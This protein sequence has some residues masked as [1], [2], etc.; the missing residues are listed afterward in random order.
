MAGR[1]APAVMRHFGV[2]F[3]LARD[4]LILLMGL[5]MLLCIPVIRAIARISRLP[6][7][8]HSQAREIEDLDTIAPTLDR[9][10]LRKGIQILMGDPKLK[11]MA[12]LIVTTG[13]AESLILYLFYWLVSDQVPITAGRTLFFSDFYIWVNAWTLV[14]LVFGSNRLINRFGLFLALAALPFA[15]F[16]G[17]AYLLYHTAVAAMYVVRIVYSS[18]EQSLYGQGLDRMMLDIEPNQAPIAR[19]LLHGLAVRVGRGM[20][21]VLVLLLALGAGISFS[22]LTIVLMIILLVW[23][24]IARSLK[25]YLHR[26]SPMS[27]PLHQMRATE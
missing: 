5:L 27:P 15:L 2:R 10:T 8:P 4:S 14:F 6:D 16:L 25:D 11:R 12:S 26:S 23:L 13:V 17:S 24:G 19:P 18:L 7:H 3:E 1:V 22:H 9:I 21:A 20:G